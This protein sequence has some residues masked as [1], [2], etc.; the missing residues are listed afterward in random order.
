MTLITNF[1]TFLINKKNKKKMADLERVKVVD[2]STD[3]ATKSVKS[4]K[5][6]I[7][8]LKGELLNLQEGTK[9]YSDVLSDIA[10]KQ[11]ELKE[12]NEQVSKSSQDFGDKIGNISG[13]ISGLTGAMQTVAGAA[14]IMGLNMGKSTEEITKMLA[15]LMSITA[16]VSAI[17]EGVKAY[18]ALNLQ[19]KQSAV[20]QK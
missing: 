19:I 8:S 12:I 16:G 15:S 2:I 6:E 20:F 1:P 3:K 11:H 9:E 14:S 5:Q 7:K 17:D 18:K 10:N 4:L 13:T